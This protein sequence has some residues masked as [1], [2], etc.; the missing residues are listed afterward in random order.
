MYVLLHEDGFIIGNQEGNLYTIKSWKDSEIRN[1]NSKIF[2]RL[3]Q[4]GAGVEKFVGRADSAIASAIGP[5]MKNLV[6]N[7]DLPIRSTNS[8]S[9]PVI[10][11]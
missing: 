2:S 5:Q 9:S 8:S 4:K 3:A 1:V 7:L 11:Y 10:C 6:S